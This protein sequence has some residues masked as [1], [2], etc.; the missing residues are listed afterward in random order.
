MTGAAGEGTYW[1]SDGNSVSSP[2][3]GA[4][5]A[6][7]G[8]EPL[9]ADLGT[10][11]GFG[12]NTASMAGNLQD[13]LMGE[14]SYV[15]GDGESFSTG[16]FPPGDRAQDAAGLAASDMLEALRI[17]ETNL[18]ALSMAA[19]V[20]ADLFGDTD[21]MNSSALNAVSYAF[22]EEGAGRPAGLPGYIDGTLH[23]RLGIGGAD[24][25]YAGGMELVE[26]R[27]MT[28]A[29]GVTVTMR[30][31]EAPDGSRRTTW[32]HADGTYRETSYDSDGNLRYETS[33]TE[34]GTLTTKM[35]DEQGDL[36]SVSE[37]R[38]G[39]SVTTQYSGGQVVGRVEQTRTESGSAAHGFIERRTIT[40]HY[41]ADGNLVPDRTRIETERTYDD[42]TVEI[43][44]TD[45]DDGTFAPDRH[46]P[47]LEGD[48]S[49]DGVDP[50]DAADLAE[51]RAEE[52]LESVPGH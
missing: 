42:G 11:R 23:D 22:A 6:T 41:D 46:I 44:T 51:H 36:T 43:G 49:P 7:G 13:D 47:A 26:E 16:G 18:R 10:L 35:W 40:E 19:H 37:T 12:E 25:D 2:N 24:G 34:G 14:A 38:G 28:Y 20:C 52:A 8:D 15:T 48:P 17:S 21:N 9:D 5:W 3:L 4:G 31:Y 39:E 27:T 32:T 50:S 45:P 30:V 29:A 33:G 1:Y